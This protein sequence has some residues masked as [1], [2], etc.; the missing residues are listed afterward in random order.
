MLMR[1]LCPAWRTSASRPDPIRARRGRV[2]VVGAGLAGLTAALTLR[3]AGWDVVVLE[4]RTR[5]GGRVHTLHGGVDGV[6]LAPGPAR[7]ARRR[8][9]RREPHGDPTAWLRRFGIATERRP[10]STSDRAGTG[11]LSTATA[12]RTRSPSSWGCERVRCSPTTCACTTSWR[13]LAETQRDR[14]RASRDRRHATDLDALSFA[15]WLDSL[16][17]RS[18]K[19]AS[20]SIRRTRRCTTRSSP[21]SRCCSCCSRWPRPPA[22][23]TRASETMRAR[24]RELDAAERDRGRARSRGRARR[25]R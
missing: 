21:T 20:S 19:R 1:A 18:R 22:C 4:A 11:P 9:D 10:G 13:E 15:E 24:G 5:V 25:A 7:R 2:I 14:S 16:R 3:D 6:P 17:A 8:V 12:G 23:P